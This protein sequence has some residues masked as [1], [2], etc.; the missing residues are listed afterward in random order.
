[1]RELLQTWDLSL[2]LKNSGETIL[3]KEVLITE[4]LG[5]KEI[6]STQNISKLI[7]TFDVLDIGIIL[8]RNKLNSLEELANI[9]A[10]NLF[11]F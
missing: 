6:V 8:K 7:E 9:F 10:K 11:V 2:S 4:F 3:S 5:H 1:M